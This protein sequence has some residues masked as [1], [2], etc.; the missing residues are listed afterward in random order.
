MPTP[1]R[2]DDRFERRCMQLSLAFW[3]FCIWKMFQ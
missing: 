1:A 3:A 2:R